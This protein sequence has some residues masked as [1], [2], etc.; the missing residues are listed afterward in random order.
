MDSSVDRRRAIAARLQNLGARRVLV[1]P[2]HVGYK[3]IGA[4]VLGVGYDN[5]ESAR[6]GTL[7]SRNYNEEQL[8]SYIAHYALSVLEHAEADCDLVCGPFAHKAARGI[9]WKPEVFVEFH[10]NACKEKPEAH[11]FEIWHEHKDEQSKVL[12]ICLVGFLMKLGLNSRGLKDVE[13]DGLRKRNRSALFDYLPLASRSFPLILVECGFLTNEQ[14]AF[15]L[16]NFY[17]LEQI[18]G[19][20][21][22]GL[23][24]FFSNRSDVH[25]AGGNSL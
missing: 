7:V 2:G 15:F 12:A 14:D 23:D 3:G 25:G 6:T 11:G 21:C 10:M 19:A 16:T 1:S 5:P 24:V 9:D 18:A 13:T 17:N 20:A 4:E 8:D 22:E